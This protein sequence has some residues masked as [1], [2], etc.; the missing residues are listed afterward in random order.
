MQGRRRDR[1]RRRARPR[2]TGC[3]PSLQVRGRDRPHLKLAAP[4]Q[5]AVSV[6]SASGRRERGRDTPAEHLRAARVPALRP[7]R[8][9]ASRAH[10]RWRVARQQPTCRR[11]R[12]RRRRRACGPCR[13]HR[14]KRAGSGEANDDGVGAALPGHDRCD[15]YVGARDGARRTAAV[16]RYAAHVARSLEAKNA[17][18]SRRSACRSAPRPG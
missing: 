8:G 1:T 12:R 4:G 11:R 9:S 15:S 7:G 6:R 5:S 16:R 17:A 13:R 10:G 14:A 3:R 2:C 18:P